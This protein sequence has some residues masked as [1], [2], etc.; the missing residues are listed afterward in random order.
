MDDENLKVQ[1]SDMSGAR[2]YDLHFHKGSA[3]G[4]MQG[5][6]GNERGRV[7]GSLGGSGVTF[8][9]EIQ[10]GTGREVYDT[11]KGTV[12]ASS[13]FVQASQNGTC[14]GDRGDL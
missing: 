8:N 12:Y 11:A 1:I 7:G 3:S 6:A 9:L 5:L 13:G 2:T 4:F 14:G 10:S